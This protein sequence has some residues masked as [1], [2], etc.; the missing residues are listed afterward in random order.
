M[1]D[2]FLIGEVYEKGSLEKDPI[3]EATVTPAVGGSWKPWRSRDGIIDLTR[4]LGERRLYG[5]GAIGYSCVYLYSETQQTVQ[6][7]FGSMHD[8]RVVVNGAL[9]KAVKVYARSLVPDQDKITNVV[10]KQGWNQVLLG[11]AIDWMGS[12]WCHE[13]RV[14]DKDGQ[15]PPQ[16]V[17][18]SCADGNADLAEVHANL[19]VLPDFAALDAAARPLEEKL[20]EMNDEL[21]AKVNAVS[22]ATNVTLYPSQF[23]VQLPPWPRMN[24]P[25]IRTSSPGGRLQDR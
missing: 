24:H 19:P 4:V 10:L 8:V 25:I 11:H 13:M 15:S 14:M 20:Q 3:G 6:L 22:A 2:D 7:W 1:I 9:V 21:V 12:E 23:P 5:A 17:Y 16:G 18:A